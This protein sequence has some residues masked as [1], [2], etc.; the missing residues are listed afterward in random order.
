MREG[1]LTARYARDAEDAKE[2][3]LSVP[4]PS[5]QTETVFF[6]RI[7]SLRTLCLK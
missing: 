1:V 4:T 2:C 5:G 6:V 7:F 3:F